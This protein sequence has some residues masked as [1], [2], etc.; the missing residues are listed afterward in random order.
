MTFHN[1]FILI[2]STDFLWSHWYGY[3]K[4]ISNAFLC[5][6]RW[7]WTQRSYYTS[8]PI[9]LLFRYIKKA[10]FVFVIRVRAILTSVLNIKLCRIIFKLVTS[11]AD[12]LNLLTKRDRKII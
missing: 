5:S 10:S 11:L 8:W 3:W 9:L 12:K 1:D 7:F 6:I 4:I 2:N